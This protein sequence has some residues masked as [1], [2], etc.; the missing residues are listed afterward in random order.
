[1]T[2]ILRIDEMASAGQFGVRRYMNLRSPEINDFDDNLEPFEYNG[3]RFYPVASENRTKK[4]KVGDP[5]KIYR[6]YDF[7]DWCKDF[8]KSIGYDYN[9]FYDSAKK[10]GYGKCDVFACKVDGS[11]RYLIPAGVTFAEFPML[12]ASGDDETFMKSLDDK[13]NAVFNK[14]ENPEIT[15]NDRVMFRKTVKPAEF[16]GTVTAVFPD[17]PSDPDGNRKPGNFVWCYEH[18]GQHGECDLGWVKTDTVPASPEEYGELLDEIIRIGYKNP[19]VMTP[20]EQD[21]FFRKAPEYEN[22]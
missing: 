8:S 18:V 9:K 5:Y 17:I 22:A 12:Y 10:H 19:V 1:M 15:R 2:H 11:I 7:N 21:A 20:E 6:R 4:T 16:E 13:L 14:A 3:V